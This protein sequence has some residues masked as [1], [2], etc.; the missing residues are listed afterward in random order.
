MKA[1]NLAAGD[2]ILRRVTSRNGIE[3]ILHERVM[4]VRPSTPGK[5]IIRTD[6]CD[7]IVPRERDIETLG[8]SA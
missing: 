1:G 3:S 5:V 2:V 4:F 8:D 7:R 6:R